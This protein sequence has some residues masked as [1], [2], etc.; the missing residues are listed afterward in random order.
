MEHADLLV[1]DGEPIGDLTGAIGAAVVDDQD[2]ELVAQSR[3]GVA[4]ARAFG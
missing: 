2:L 4:G 3:K 1:L